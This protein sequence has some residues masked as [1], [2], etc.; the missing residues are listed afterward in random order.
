MLEKRY[1]FKLNG[2]WVE[3]ESPPAATLLEVLREKLRLTGVKEGCCRGD[4]GACTVLLNGRPVHSCLTIMEHVQGAEVLTVEGLARNGA[5]DALQRAFIEVGAV[6]CGYCTPGML[7]AAK[8]LLSVNP[9]PSREE[10][11]EALRGNL[12]RCTGYAMLIKAVLRAAEL[13]GKR[14]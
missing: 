12:C 10:V 6:Q 13:M 14:R 9:N 11:V 1:R 4:C 5:L 7:M 2:E 3:V 8:A